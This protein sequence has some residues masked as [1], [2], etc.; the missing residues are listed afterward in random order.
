LHCHAFIYKNW[1]PNF[2]RESNALGIDFKENG[3]LKQGFVLQNY[4]HALILQKKI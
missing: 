2:V 4:G 3:G 1:Q